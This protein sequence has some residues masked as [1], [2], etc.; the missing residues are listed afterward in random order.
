MN[1]RMKRSTERQKG[2]NVGEEG[3]VKRCE[4]EEEFRK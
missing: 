4:K 2:E 1:T 3:R